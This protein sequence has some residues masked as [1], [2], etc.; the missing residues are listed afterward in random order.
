MSTHYND[1]E[2]RKEDAINIVIQDEDSNQMQTLRAS[3]SKDISGKS[4][5]DSYN[6]D[7]DIV[8]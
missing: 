5:S 6:S 7:E 3:N 8:K 4:R 1:E 2:R